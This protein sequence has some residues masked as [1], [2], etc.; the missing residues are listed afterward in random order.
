MYLSNYLSNLLSNFND[1]R[2][3]RNIK[4]LCSKIIEHKSIQLWSISDDKAEF[5][6]S[7]RLIDGSLKTV[8]DDKKI[9]SALREHGTASLGHENRL[10]IIYDPCD[11]RKEHMGK[12][13][14]L[15]ILRY[16]AMV[17]LIM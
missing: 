7:K 6:R 3:K 17:I 9:T 11:I 12:R 15:L 8:I 5:E 4:N 13:F 14:I 16:I 2:T 1:S 10:I